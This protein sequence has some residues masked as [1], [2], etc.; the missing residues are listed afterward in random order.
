V[1][2]SSCSLPAVPSY[3]LPESVIPPPLLTPPTSSPSAMA[4]A[5]RQ[6]P[7][8]IR[9]VSRGAQGIPSRFRRNGSNSHRDKSS[10]PVIM[11]RRSDSRSAVDAAHDLAEFESYHFAE[12]EMVDEYGE[13]IEGLGLTS[14]RPSVTSIPSSTVSAPKRNSRLEQG[15]LMKKATK[16]HMKDIVLRLDLVSAKVCWDSTRSSKS[17]SFYIDDIRDFHSGEGAKLYREELGYREEW[18]PYWFTIVYLDTNRIKDKT[19]QMHIVA[20]DRNI[21]DSWKE[22]LQKVSRDRIDMMAG[23]MGFAEKSARLVW[24]NE[25]E[26]RYPND[27]QAHLRDAE[28]IDFPSITELCRRLHINCSNSTLRTYFDK[29]DS[30]K[31]GSLDQSQFLVFVRRLKERKDVKQIFKQFT[32]AP[33]AGMDKPTFFAFLQREQGIDVEANVDIL[34]TT[35]EKFAYAS[36]KEATTQ[37][38]SNPLP[39]SMNF[40]AFQTFLASDVHNSVFSPV[41][42]SLHL[43]RPLNEYF[44]SSSHNTYLLGRQVADISSTEAYVAALQKGC[45]CLEI[46]CWDGP[47][48][49]PIVTHGRTFTKGIT[50]LDAVKVIN[51]YA[52]VESAYPL[53]LSL[54]VHCGTDQQLEMVKMMKKEFGTKLVLDLLDRDSEALP[55]PEELK[56]RILI[57]VKG[58]ADELDAGALVSQLSHRK[59]ERSFSSP[60]SRPVLLNDNTISNSPLTLSPPSMS[61]PERTGSF[62]A[63]PRT[64]ATSCTVPTPAFISSAEE[65]DSPNATA[66]EDVREKKKSKKAKTSNI[67]KD[68]GILGVYTRG[69][70]FSEFGAHDANTFNHVISFNERAFEKLTRP[71]AFEKQLLEEHNMRCLMRVYPGGYRINSSNFDPLNCWRRGVQMAALNWQTY[72]L[73]QQLNEAMF[74]GGDNRTGYVLKPAELR[75]ENQTP[76]LGHRRAAK[77]EVKFTVQIISAQQLPRP[78]GLAEDANISPFVQF[79][80]YCAEDAGPNATGTGGQDVAARKD[81]YSGIGQPLR[82]KTRIVS[83]NGYNPEFKDEI[84]MKVTTRYPDLVFVRW[85]VWNTV[86]GKTQDHA[87]LAQFTAKLNSIQQGYHHLPLFDGNGEQYLFSRL[88]CKI[89]KQDIVDAPPAAISQHLDSYRSSKEPVQLLE[90]ANKSSSFIRRLIRAPSERKKRKEERTNSDIRNSDSPAQ[91]LV[92]RSNTLEH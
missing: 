81:G 19:K 68:L 33:H 43:H 49:K 77:K 11:R 7:G 84:E 44:I 15:T 52:F 74:T 53:I 30:G 69:I 63:S 25:M 34:T 54:E 76:V 38:G 65:S 3:A 66:A 18:S 82:K 59:R 79:E 67:T 71:G 90:T 48:D 47:D 85:T 88:F 78:R 86:D 13:P 89:K 72:D 4:E 17:K 41:S 10:G 21:F 27:A 23:L 9:R 31:S 58:P 12:D 6:T 91:S 8:L 2:L 24:N 20:P 75:L 1:P 32:P 50:F 62:W 57:K 45:R 5:L 51:K 16:R 37:D 56:G 61:P 64:S 55:S 14:T 87:P 80:M 40:R 92:S 26:K 70:K 60:W 36:R 46:D 73:G 22:T 29:A 83:G 39:L 28:L 42:P 35:F